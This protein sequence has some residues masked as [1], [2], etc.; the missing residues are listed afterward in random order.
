LNHPVVTVGEA[1]VSR[2]AP[3]AGTRLGV[4]WGLWASRPVEA[5]ARG[6]ALAA[7][8]VLF[9]DAA[10]TIRVVY[11]LRPSFLLFGLAL[12]LGLPAAL[13]GWRSLSPWLRWAGAGLLAVHVL[14]VV[15]GDQ[16]VLVGNGRAGGHRDLLYLADLGMGLG[17]IGLLTGL[18]SGGRSRP[19]LLALCGG[20]VLAAGYGLYQWVAQH[21]GLPLSDVNNTLDSNGVTAGGDQGLGLL[22]WE[23]IRG[24]FVEPHFLGAY[25]ASIAPVLAALAQ[26]ARCWQR[27]AAVLAVGGVLAALVLTSS[28]PAVAALG[29]GFV[30]ALAVFCVAQGRVRAAALAGAMV[31]VVAIGVPVVFTAPQVLASATGRSAADLQLTAQ[32]RQTAWTSSIDVW[33]RRPLLGYGPGQSSIQLARELAGPESTVPLSSQGLWAA[34]LVDTGALGFAFWVMLLGGLFAAAAGRA[35]R[36]ASPVQILVLFAATTALVSAQMSGDRLGLS[37]W[38]LLGLLMAVSTVGADR[39]RAS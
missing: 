3:L 16:A 24:T 32:F 4:L 33:S 6:L 12:A 20:G 1:N 10:G 9:L 27:G 30:V 28:A 14:A 22:G 31:A 21:Y 23:R 18:F 17:V 38:T 19:L 35:V 26:L 39:D 11:T 2:T 8:L 7:A 25:L 36:A 34:T 37:T 29:A 13:R 5:A 15:L